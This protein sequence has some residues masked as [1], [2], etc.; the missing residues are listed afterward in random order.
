MQPLQRRPLTTNATTNKPE[1][2]CCLLL[3]TYTH[4][5]ASP[6]DFYPMSPAERSKWLDDGL[7]MTEAAYDAVGDLVAKE[8]LSHMC[9]PPAQSN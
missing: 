7:H 4:T 8:I 6:F 3:V 9:Q 5:Q 2:C 1:P